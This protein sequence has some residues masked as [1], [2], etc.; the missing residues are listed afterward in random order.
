MAGRLSSQMGISED[1]A[2][3]GLQQT[4]GLMVPGAPAQ[5]APAPA[6]KPRAKKTTT[7]KAAAG[8]PKKAKKKKS[9]SDFMDL[10]DDTTH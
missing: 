8:T 1:E 7:K 9:E 10:L 2:I 3:L 5:P 6:K 4:M